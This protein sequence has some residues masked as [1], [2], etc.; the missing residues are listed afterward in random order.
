MSIPVDEGVK[1]IFNVKVFVAPENQDEFWAHFK[2][3]FD[4]VIAE[5]QCRFFVV[6]RDQN[7]PTCLSWSEGWTEDIQWMQEV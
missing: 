6:G 4:K 5:P 3:A 2:P 1:M 7:D